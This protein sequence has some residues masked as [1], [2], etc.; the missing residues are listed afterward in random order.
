MTIQHKAFHCFATAALLFVV[1]F[2]F[3][4]LSVAPI[5]TAIMAVKVMVNDGL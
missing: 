3:R 1:V 4:P 2:V 5:T